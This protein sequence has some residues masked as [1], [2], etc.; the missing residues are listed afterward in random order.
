M[1]TSEQRK[2]IDNELKKSLL[3][4]FKFNDILHQAF[5]E[6]NGKKVENAANNLRKAII[7]I[8]DP[9]VSKL[10]N[11]SKNKLAEINE[12][13]DRNKNNQNYH[14]VSMALIHILKYD[15]G[16]GFNAILVQW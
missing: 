16:S 6:Y 8:K 2:N 10:L 1:K 3:E 7:R 11:F 4:V 5:F 9:E 15:I 13:S 14:L 12:I